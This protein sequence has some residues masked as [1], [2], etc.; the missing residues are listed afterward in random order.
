MQTAIFGLLLS[1][2][3]T[4]VLAQKYPER[5]R[6]VSM[7]VPFGPGGASDA[8]ARTL[9]EKFAE[10]WGVTAVVENKP[11][12][13]FMVGAAALANAKPDGYTMGLLTLGFVQNQIVKPSQRYNPMKDFTPIGMVARTPLALV[14]NAKSPIKSFKDL[15]EI[16]KSDPKSLNFSSCCTAMLFSIEMLKKSAALEGTH[17]PYKGS[18]P[19]VNAVLGGDTVYTVDTVF[20]VKEFV[21]AGKLR[22]LVV[23]SRERVGALPDVPNLSE[24]GVP[25][26][27]ET[28]TWYFLAFP[29]GTPQEMVVTANA[30]LNK[31]LNMPDV[32]EK[33][34]RFIVKPSPSSPGDVASLMRTDFDRY[35]RLAKENNMKFE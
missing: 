19:S 25:G 22:A 9:A 1:A 26:T 17:I 10:Q 23:T 35:A 5:G 12:G 4:T 31:I 34:A 33:F 8:M 24:V 16:S 30:T 29:N 32:K 14:V 2:S 28:D 7:V 3:A 11:G 20:S 18:V 27:F 21:A 6:T 13:E 15:Q